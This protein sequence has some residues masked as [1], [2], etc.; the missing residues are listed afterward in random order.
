MEEQDRQRNFDIAV[1]SRIRD[2]A[3]DVVARAEAEIN[4]EVMKARNAALVEQLAELREPASIDPT[5]ATS[6]G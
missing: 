3:P 1:L 4:L 6:L 5:E 2:I